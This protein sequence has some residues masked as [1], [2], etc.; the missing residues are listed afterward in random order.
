MIQKHH[1]FCTRMLLGHSLP[2]QSYGTE[3]EKW[4]RTQEDGF[5]NIRQ[6]HHYTTVFP[7]HSCYQIL[8]CLTDKSHRCQG[9]FEGC[10]KQLKAKAN[11]CDF[12]IIADR[13]IYGK[14]SGVCI[15]G[16]RV[17]EFVFGYIFEWSVEHI[18]LWEAMRLTHN[19]TIRC[20]IYVKTYI[21]YAM[22]IGVGIIILRILN[23]HRCWHPLSLS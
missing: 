6:L 3:R 17:M 15:H 22:F 21:M 9:Q 2:I 14:R 1:L 8:F 5:K 10:L 7:K 11:A 16:Q 23:K 19:L 20:S 4:L 12:Y 13:T 18:A